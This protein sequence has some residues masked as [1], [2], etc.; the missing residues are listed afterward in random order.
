MTFFEIVEKYAPLYSFFLQNASFIH[1]IKIK[2]VVLK[3]AAR[4]SHYGQFES[5]KTQTPDPQTPSVGE[6][7]PFL[8]FLILPFHTLV[9]GIFTSRRRLG[10]YIN[11]VFCV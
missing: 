6:R 10:K 2:F 7:I 3:N 11:G 4:R 9:I 1:A 8:L 5:A